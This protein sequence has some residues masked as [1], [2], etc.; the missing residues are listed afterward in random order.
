MRER[1]KHWSAVSALVLAT[2]ASLVACSD[3]GGKNGDASGVGTASDTVL[4][5]ENFFEEVTKAQI[6]AGTSHVVMSLTS[7][8]QEI[9]ADGDV[10]LGDSVADTALVMRLDTGKQGL[11]S[12][13]MRLVDRIFYLNFGPMTQNKFAKV[14][15]TDDSNPIGR[16][17]GDLVD[18]IDPIKQL[19]QFKGAVTSFEKQGDPIELDGVQAQPYRVEVDPSKVE[20][21][22]DS[23]APLPKKLSYTMYIGPDNLPRRLR[24]ELPD[25]AGS[26][27]TSVTMDY[28]KW[29]ESV[30]ISAPKESE[31]SDKDFLS[32]LGGGTPSPS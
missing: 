8:G 23:G 25:V 32:Q 14:D 19:E 15:L 18:S 11:G 7:A 29:G 28:T 20:Q 30:S 2:G 5:Q 6:K 10:R 17:Y 21:Y 27:P 26:G 16:Q 13:E 1:L 12:L 31:I 4:T 9:K 3:D 24:S 22:K